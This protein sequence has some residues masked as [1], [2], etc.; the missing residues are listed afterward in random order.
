M[1]IQLVHIVHPDD[2]SRVTDAIRNALLYN[3]VI[4]V[5]IVRQ[6]DVEIDPPPFHVHLGD[7]RHP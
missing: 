6:L 2:V 5:Y 4:Q 7:D 3:Q 1:G